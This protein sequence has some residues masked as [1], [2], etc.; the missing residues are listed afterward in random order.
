MGREVIAQWYERFAPGLQPQ[1]IPES[2][3]VDGII[4]PLTPYGLQYRILLPDGSSFPRH[5]SG[6]GAT[7]AVI[8]DTASGDPKAIA[9][10]ESREESGETCAKFCGGFAGH[11]RK[12]AADMV[13]V[14]NNLDL[15]ETDDVSPT[16][17][18]HLYEFFLKLLAR[19]Y[20]SIITSPPPLFYMVDKPIGYPNIK[21]CS[22]MGYVV[23][24]ENLLAGKEDEAEEL[25][26][27]DPLRD[28]DDTH[29]GDENSDRLVKYLQ[30]NVEN[31]VVDYFKLVRLVEK[32][33]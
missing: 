19:E 14:Y 4:F 13:R 1:N 2:A 30:S 11:N 21:I 24:Q 32:V 5:Q 9:R 16:E 15:L 26:L 12:V 22:V 20:G 33:K 17:C 25:G 3:V 23:Y 29:M 8:H 18:P 6:P 28:D 7:I 27:F 10:M 31:L